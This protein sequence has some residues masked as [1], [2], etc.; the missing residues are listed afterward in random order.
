MIRCGPKVLYST[1][2]RELLEKSIFKLSTLIVDYPPRKTK[3]RNQLTEDL[4]GNSGARLIL[5][6]I[7]LSNF[8]KWSTMTRIYSK[9]INRLCLQTM[10]PEVGQ[11][12]VFVICFPS[13]NIFSLS[14]NVCSSS[15]VECLFAKWNVFSSSRMLFRRVECLF[16]ES[17]CLFVKPPTPV[18]PVAMPIRWV[19]ITILC[20]MLSGPTSTHGLHLRSVLYLFAWSTY[21]FS[22]FLPLP[23]SWLIQVSLWPSNCDFVTHSGAFI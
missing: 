6:R 1:E 10:E 17:Q 4:H 21:Y 19:A 14:S 11:Y 9:T 16:V 3:S 20:V 5:S 7:S 22:I 13:H 2:F 12:T 8:V 23:L 18:R 15:R